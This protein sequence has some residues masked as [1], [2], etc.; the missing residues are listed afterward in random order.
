[1]IKVR[2]AKL[3]GALGSKAFPYA[4]NKRERR[5]MVSFSSFKRQFQ[6]EHGRSCVFPSTLA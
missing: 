2:I 1:M 6:Q 3:P 4:K 5:T